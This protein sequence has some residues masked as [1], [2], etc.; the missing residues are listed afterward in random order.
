MVD[1]AQG[2]RVVDMSDRTR[3]GVACGFE[4][5]VLCT[6]DELVRT[7]HEQCGSVARP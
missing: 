2:G 4:G 6:Q 7:E 1:T 3:E 5:R